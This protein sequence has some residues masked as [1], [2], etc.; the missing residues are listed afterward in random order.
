LNAIHPSNMILSLHTAMSPTAV[1][2]ETKL[3][4]RQQSTYQSVHLHD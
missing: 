3:Q 4:F 2:C 1:M